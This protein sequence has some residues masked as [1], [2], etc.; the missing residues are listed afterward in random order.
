ML[1]NSL[2]A[3]RHAL[4]TLR[5][6]ALF[7]LTALTVLALGIGANTAVFT[8]VDSIL[9]RPLQYREPEQLYSVE[10]IVPQF[11]TSP[12]CCR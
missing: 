8:V 11:A 6:D 7:S 2:T 12:Q 3:I 5:T 4:R 10:E 9:L 1:S